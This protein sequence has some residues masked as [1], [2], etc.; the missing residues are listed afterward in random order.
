[1]I[2]INSNLLMEIQPGFDE[3]LKKGNELLEAIRPMVR[4]IRNEKEFE[5]ARNKMIIAGFENYFSLACYRAACKTYASVI[6]YDQTGVISYDQR[7]RFSNFCL[8][9][10][11]EG[12]DIDIDS[13]RIPCAID[14]NRDGISVSF[15]V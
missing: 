7:K 15:T 11:L 3:S 1:M 2:A 6:S 5:N 4:K 8:S 10:F 14:V 12:F 9:F 13:E